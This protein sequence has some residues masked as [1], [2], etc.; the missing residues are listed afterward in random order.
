MI[1]KSRNRAG[2]LVYELVEQPDKSPLE[3]VEQTDFFSLLRYEYPIEASLTFHP[4]NEGAIKPQYRD[5]LIKQGLLKGVSDVTSLYP[6]FKHDGF[7][8][9]MKRANKKEASAVSKEQKKFLK[10][11]EQAGKFSCVAYGAVPMWWA[12]CDYLGLEFDD[13]MRHK[14]DYLVR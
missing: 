8:G 14:A 7:C 9:E 13:P 12:W 5:K 3:E 6:G 4:V 11:A 2:I 10:N 1:K